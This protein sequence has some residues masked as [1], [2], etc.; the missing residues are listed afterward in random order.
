MDVGV[1]GFQISKW[2][3]RLLFHTSLIR[4]DQRANLFVTKPQ[5]VSVLYNVSMETED[6]KFSGLS[7]NKKLANTAHHSTG[8]SYLALERGRLEG[9][10][11]EDMKEMD[12]IN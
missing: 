12:D 10:G 1:D 2:P 8:T 5:D 7:G 4:Q 6:E 3:I 11:Y 9:M